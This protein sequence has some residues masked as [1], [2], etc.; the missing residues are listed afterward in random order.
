MLSIAGRVCTVFLYISWS[1][2]WNGS[3]GSCGGLTK[4]KF[5]FFLW[6]GLCDS[7]DTSRVCNIFLLL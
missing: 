6:H 4:G 3:L 1:P 2:I 7:Q 5:C